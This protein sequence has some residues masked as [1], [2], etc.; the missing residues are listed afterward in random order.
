MN[1]LSAAKRRRAGVQVAASPMFKS[2]AA[3]PTATARPNPTPVN[4]HNSSPS[5]S[6]LNDTTKIDTKKPMPLQQ[7]IS[8]LDNRILYL[9]NQF[10]KI[11][12]EPQLVNT[13]NLNNQAVKSEFNKEQIEDMIIN[14]IKN[15]M[16]EFDH[17]YE[18]L[19]NEIVN[20]K[21]I[22]LQLQSYTLDVNKTLLGDRDH[23]L[24]LINQSNAQPNQCISANIAQE[25]KDAEEESVDEATQDAKEAIVVEETQDAEE[26]SVVEATQ[27]A[28]ETSVVE[29]SQEIPE[30]AHFAEE[31]QEI[32]EEAQI[33]LV[34][35]EAQEDDNTDKKK[36]RRKGKNKNVMQVS[37]DDA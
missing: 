1:S 4:I 6:I 18:L 17:R 33:T 26:A 8:V 22:V 27:D 32:P 9:E 36:G 14:T 24:E 13:D 12:G 11:S 5:P 16:A 10:V 7:V 3:A 2:G 21:Q 20:L 28:E 25:A 31:S 19:A 35:E 37:L 29:E 23:L 30:E 34:V 15:H